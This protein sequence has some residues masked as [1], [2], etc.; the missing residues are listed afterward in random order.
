[1]WLP[2]WICVVAVVVIV[3]ILLEFEHVKVQVFLKTD[4]ERPR[5]HMGED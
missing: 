3:V 1:M 2:K 4:L 5:S